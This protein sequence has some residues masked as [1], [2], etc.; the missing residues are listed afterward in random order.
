[1]SGLL[2]RENAQGAN[3]VRQDSGNSWKIGE[4]RWTST[5]TLYFL[6]DRGI[7]KYMICP[8]LN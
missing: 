4:V 2:R 1:M 6:Y 5:N 7:S 3:L 8:I